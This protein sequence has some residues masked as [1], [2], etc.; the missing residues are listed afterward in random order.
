MPL[1]FLQYEMSQNMAFRCKTSTSSHLLTPRYGLEV[2]NPTQALKGVKGRDNTYD[3]N[4]KW[5][6]TF[7][8]PPKKIQMS[9]LIFDT[10]LWFEVQN[11]TQELKSVKARAIPLI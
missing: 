3:L 7:P 10:L 8:R 6:R 5:A 9:K 11:I 1:L 2:Q 4:F